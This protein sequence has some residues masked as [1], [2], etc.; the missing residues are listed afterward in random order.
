MHDN[1]KQDHL[2]PRTKMDKVN[3]SVYS[4]DE[5]DSNFLLVFQFQN[6]L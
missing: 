4:T 1:Q 5:L 2:R 6:F 3:V